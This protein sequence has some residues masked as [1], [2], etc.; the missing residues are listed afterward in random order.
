M[1]KLQEQK[2]WELKTSIFQFKN[3]ESPNSLAPIQFFFIVDSHGLGIGWMIEE[4]DSGWWKK[5]RFIP[6]HDRQSDRCNENKKYG[7]C[8]W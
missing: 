2:R 5:F 1:A 3:Y 7:V 4:H 6:P 8:E